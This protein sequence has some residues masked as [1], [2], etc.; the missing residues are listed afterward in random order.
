MHELYLIWIVTVALSADSFNFF[1][2]PGLAGSLDVFEMNF[3][4][5]TEVDN[6]AKKIEEA[7]KKFYKRKMIG[8]YSLTGSCDL[9]KDDLQNFFFWQI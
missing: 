3:W 1:D 5:L 8:Q 9:E 2:L 7:C 4:V 6:R